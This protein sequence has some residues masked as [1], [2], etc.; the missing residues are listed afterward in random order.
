MGGL[1]N[2]KLSTANNETTKNMAPMTLQQTTFGEIMIE[3]DVWIGANAVVLSTVRIAHGS[4]IAAGCVV[5]QSTELH[6]IIAS[7]PGRKIS[8]RT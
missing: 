2:R 8:E 3:D 4:V 7:I 1:Q 5:S 6:S